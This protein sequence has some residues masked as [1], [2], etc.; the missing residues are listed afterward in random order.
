MP[1][2]KKGVILF[3]V[4]ATILI[5]VLL[6]GVVLSIISSQSRLT[7][8][9]VSRIKAYYAGKAMMVYTFEKLRAG[10]WTLPAT[11]S[12][13][14]ACSSNYA[15]ID[16]VT[17]TYDLP[18]TDADIPYKV[19]VTINPLKSTNPGGTADL[20]VKTQYTD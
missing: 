7:H 2:N 1:H 8:H 4:L 17:K 6:S 18:A 13:Y 9:K 10:T 14:Y 5:I 19:Q 15:C 11:G 20:Q 16:G 12:V 3:I